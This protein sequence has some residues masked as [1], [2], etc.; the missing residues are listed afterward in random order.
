[1]EQ[2]KYGFAE[3]SK[4]RAKLALEQLNKPREE[5]PKK[6]RSVSE[7]RKQLYGKD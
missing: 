3:K 6:G 7:V 1:M 5:E 2:S 4:E